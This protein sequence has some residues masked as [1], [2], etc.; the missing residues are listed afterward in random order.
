MGGTY[1]EEVEVRKKKRSWSCGDEEENEQYGDTWESTN[2]KSFATTHSY[3][4]RME[5][6]DKKEWWCAMMRSRVEDIERLTH[7][8]NYTFSSY[9]LDIKDPESPFSAKFSLHEGWGIRRKRIKRQNPTKMQELAS[10]QTVGFFPQ[11]V[12]LFADLDIEL[13]GVIKPQVSRPGLL[14]TISG[15][16]A[17]RGSV[18][19]WHFLIVIPKH[20][21]PRI[22]AISQ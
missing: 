10:F 17:K 19:H 9:W 3:L 8:S 2:V 11:S 21:N 5:R 15:W 6:S 7:K 1:S 16:P 4:W 18:A 20:Q 22:M 14:L 12:N 13:C